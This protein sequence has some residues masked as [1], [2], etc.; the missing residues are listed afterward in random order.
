MAGLPD[1]DPRNELSRAAPERRDRP[2]EMAQARNVSCCQGWP[3]ANGVNQDR[4]GVTG[5]N[6]VGT[7]QRYP[8][9]CAMG[10]HPRSVGCGIWRSHV[11]QLAEATDPGW[12]PRRASA[13]LRALAL[14]ARLGDDSSRRA[15]QGAVV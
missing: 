1:P 11:P 8:A 5:K 4:H 10:A 14:L 9:E 2:G 13:R 12:P 3:G 15:H 6:D 7:E